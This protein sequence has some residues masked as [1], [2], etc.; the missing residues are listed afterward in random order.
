MGRREGNEAQLVVLRSRG[1]SG[2][3]WA[4]HPQSCSFIGRFQENCAILRELVTLRAQKSSLL[5]FSTHADYVLE[6]NMA[7]SSQVVATFL[8][9]PLPPPASPSLPP[10]V[11]GGSRVV[12]D[13]SVMRPQSHSLCVLE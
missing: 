2:R 3:W 5:G 4:Q 8:G 12:R 13:H 11:P 7:K 1:P 6:M 9:N 10:W